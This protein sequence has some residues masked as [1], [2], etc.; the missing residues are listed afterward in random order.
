[1]LKISFTSSKR[2]IRNLLEVEGPRLYCLAVD[3]FKGEYDKNLAL[4]TLEFLEKE[5]YSRKE[6]V[7]FLR[8]LNEEIKKFELK[9]PI[10][11]YTENSYPYSYYFRR[12][13]ER[14]VPIK[15]IRGVPLENTE[16]IPKTYEDLSSRINPS[17][18]ILYKIINS[19]R[20]GNK[21]LNSIMTIVL[22]T[23][24]GLIPFSC[25]NFEPLIKIQPFSIIDVTNYEAVEKWS[26]KI[27]LR[28]EL[29]GEIPPK[30]SNLE[31]TAF[32]LYYNGKTKPITWGKIEKICSKILLRYFINQ[33]EDFIQK[34]T[35]QTAILFFTGKKYLNE[36]RRVLEEYRL[37]NPKLDITKEFLK[38]HAGDKEYMSWGLGS[39]NLIGYYSTDVCGVRKFY[40]GKLE[41]TIRDIEGIERGEIVY[42]SS[43]LGTPPR[44]RKLLRFF[45]I[46]FDEDFNKEEVYAKPVECKR[47][48]IFFDFN[49]KNL[50]SSEK[51]L[52]W[53]K[54]Q[55]EEDVQELERFVRITNPLQQWTGIVQLIQ[56]K[57]KKE[58]YP[59]D[60][61]SKVR[62]DG[63]YDY[64]FSKFNKTPLENAL[65]DLGLTREKETEEV[66]TAL[67]IKSTLQKLAK[68]GKL[69]HDARRFCTISKQNLINSTEVPLLLSIGNYTYGDFKIFGIVDFLGRTEDGK[70]HI[71]DTKLEA[72]FSPTRGQRYQVLAAGM[73]IEQNYNIR[74]D[75]GSNYY[76][77]SVFREGILFTYSYF[78][79]KIPDIVNDMIEQVYDYHRIMDC[80]NSNNLNRIPEYFKKY[81]MSK[82]RM[83]KTERLENVRKI[84]EEKLCVQ[85]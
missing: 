38:K 54:R 49:D 52:E 81:F 58:I 69:I 31:A 23:P 55:K 30:D 56:E 25:K 65:E 57:I 18:D 9:S 39:S 16:W 51:Y 83:V 43:L 63:S 20:K 37:Y 10:V 74:F 44:D 78:P 60:L 14:I 84:I 85:V 21:P 71:C 33:A 8:N 26:R 53:K 70:C 27:R 79:Q 12:E 28:S 67:G 82:K 48:S 35:Q 47:G 32:E 80:I 22:V 64:S 40:P 45:E 3:T 46:W 76:H 68:I 62:E 34:N 15:N 50:C 29:M 42:N 36:F 72:S 4:S 61:N 5:L 13:K 1:M 66:V 77:T 11:L 59:L 6:K 19:Y 73:A 2:V 41:R 75:S 24:I 7:E 17:L